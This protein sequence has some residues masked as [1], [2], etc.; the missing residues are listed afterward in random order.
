MDF[1]FSED[2]KDLKEAVGKFVQQAIVPIEMD[3]EENNEIPE[4]AIEQ[5]KEMGLFGVSIPEE[6]GGLGLSM[7]GKC[8]VFEEIGKTHNGFTTLVGAHAGIGTVGIVELG[9]EAQ[10]EKYL[11]KMAAGDWI[12][13]F[14]LTEASA[15]SHASNIKTTAVKKGDKYII[16]GAKQYI[17][18]AV[19]A[20]VFTVMAVTDS[21]KGAK[22][23]TA[24]I[25]EKDFPGFT[26]GKVEDKMGLRGSHSAEIFFDN[27]EVPSENILGT[28]GMGYINALKILA[29]GR[30]GLAARNLGSCDK[31][32]E[33][34]MNYALE[35]EQFGKPIFEHQAVQ[36]MLSEMKMD[37]E[38]LRSM[39]YRVA[40]MTDEEERIV[41]EAS[42]AKLYGSEVYNKIAD[43][44]IQIHG[45][46]GY[47]KEYPIE[48]YYRDARITSIYEGTSQI[49]KNIIA[50]E[51]KREYS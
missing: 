26:M 16:N 20:H 50:S 7:V 35:R 29:N 44:A 28:V 34:S 41:K 33:Y 48:R 4:E 1:S 40:W 24:F 49:Q 17:T 39:V 10:K 46:I 13:A 3:I 42:M 12:G 19:D 21:E 51:L 25:V 8:A 47:I 2:V 5:T 6:Y 38:T 18:N 9:T 23:I 22:G 30:T 15:G 11:P 14:A 27:M 37:I 43:L 45:G 32:F 31:L 36:H